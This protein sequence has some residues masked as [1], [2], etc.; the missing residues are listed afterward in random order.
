MS[1]PHAHATL[2]P[3]GNPGTSRR[4]LW[5]QIHLWLGWLTAIPLLAVCVTGV[6]LSFEEE[7]Y[8]WEQPE[9]YA[10][11]PTA[12]PMGLGE[13]LDLLDRAELHINHLEVPTDPTHAYLAFAT[14]T[15]PD[16]TRRGL[17]AYV[18]PYQRTLTHE[19]DNPTFI[20]KMEVWHRTLS[21]GV[22]GRWIVAVSSLLLAGIALA[23]LVLWWPM[24]RGTLRRFSNQR[25]ALDWHTVVGLAA[26]VPLVILGITG[27]TFTWG[28][29]VFPVLDGWTGQSS[30]AV[31]PKL[32]PLP[33]E[34][35]SGPR[36]TLATSAQAIRA[37]HPD[38]QIRGVQGSRPGSDVPYKFFLRQPDSMLPGASLQV[39]VD[40]RT[41]REIGRW[42]ATAS[43]PVGAYRRTFYIAHTGHG[44]S[45]WARSLW[46]LASAAG[47]LLI[48]TGA[49]LSVRRWT[50]NRQ[51]SVP[52]SAPL[53]G[54]E[55]P[56]VRRLQTKTPAR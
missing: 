35:T 49:W 25:R 27:I 38:W 54:R 48:L 41:G 16:G 43:G 32:A 31:V 23:G 1:A 34:A 39:F 4:R 12:N 10:L 24:R 55:R 51:R 21:G 14:G 26:L 47:G 3:P 53:A 13:V 37:L 2:P 30:I 40:P 17:R 36:Q 19:W 52:T 15:A 7:F 33:E 44:F 29:I 28:R 18:D 56:V 50:R 5:F 42:D 6:L 9:H 46:A 11:T 20:R 45:P 22:A 8:R